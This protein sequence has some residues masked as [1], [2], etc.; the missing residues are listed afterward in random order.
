MVATWKCKWSEFA[1]VDKMFR[2]ASSSKCS[3][4][5]I[6]NAETVGYLVTNKQNHATRRR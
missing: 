3:E 1:T 6:V 4:T 5:R 2:D